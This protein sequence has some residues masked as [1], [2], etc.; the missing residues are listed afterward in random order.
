MNKILVG[1]VIGV[2]A[3]ALAG[4]VA[5]AQQTEEVRVEASRVVKT[6]TTKGVSGMEIVDMSLSYGV[7]YAGLDLKTHAGAME[8]E[9][10]LNSAARKACKELGRQYP[11]STPGDA[12]CAKAAAEKPLAR[13][14]ELEAAAAR[15]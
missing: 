2:L 15:N 11:D 14:H 12:E 10:R 8:L 4:T 13:A 3:S 6:V 5:V 1:T 7:S 9:R